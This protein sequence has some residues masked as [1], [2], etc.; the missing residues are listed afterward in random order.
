MFRC[1]T[2]LF[3]H[4]LMIAPA[5]SLTQIEPPLSDWVPSETGETRQLRIA[6]SDAERGTQR[7]ER[8]VLVVVG[9]GGEETAYW[10]NTRWKLEP[11]RAYMFRVRLKGEGGEGWAL[12]GATAVNFDFIPT[13]EWQTAEYVFRAPADTQ[14]AFI[15]VGHWLWRGEI[16]FDQPQLVPVEVVH[17]RYDALTLGEG[18][19]IR[20]GRYTFISRFDGELSNA[21]SPLREFTANFD[22]NRWA[23]SPNTQATYRHFVGDYRMRSGVVRLSAS[24]EE[25]G[26]LAIH[27]RKDGERWQKVYTVRKRGAHEFKIPPSFLPARTLEVRFVG[28]SGSVEIDSYVLETELERAPQAMLSGRSLTLYPDQQR[29][30]IRVKPIAL[31][32]DAQGQWSLLAEVAST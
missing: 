17:T 1:S 6:V 19:T 31:Q 28:Q 16:L 32:R 4:L 24:S 27:L 12:L 26:A 14:E 11:N 21:Q 10:R 7:A 8:T 13:R 20:N 25:D 29:D 18:E 30:D 2:T 3:M 5:S 9:K 23:F 15:R 22:T